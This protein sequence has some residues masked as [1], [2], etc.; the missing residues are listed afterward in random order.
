[1]KKSVNK[2]YKYTKTS[3]YKNKRAKD[4]SMYVLPSI[5]C[6]SDN[7]KIIKLSKKIIKNEA[8]KLKKPVSKLTDKQ[9]ANA[10]LR[11][12]QE[13][14]KYED[15]GNTRYGALKSL[16]MKRLNCVDSTHITVALLRVANIHA[17]NIKKDGHC[18]PR[19]YFGGKWIVGETTIHPIKI[20]FGKCSLTYTNWVKHS[21][22]PGSYIDSYKYSKKFVQHGKNKQWLEIL[23]YHNIDGKWLSYY[24]LKG[25]ADT[26]F[27][28]INLNKLKIINEG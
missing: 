22:N 9:K 17:K 26:S 19:A 13:K 20:N 12:V 24:V 21:A 11:W 5:D 18:W 2:N 7:R 28:K 3:K 4:W 6:E 23:E 27:S 16:K 8:K 10:I 25:N 14:F 1:M 15:Y